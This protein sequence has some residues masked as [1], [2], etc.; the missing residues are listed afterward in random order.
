MTYEVLTQPTHGTLTECAD[1][2]CRYS[3]Q[4]GYTGF[5]SFTF[6]TSDGTSF[7]NT[8]TI[9]IQVH[10]PGTGATWDTSAT[11]APG[12]PVS[13]T[14][15]GY[16]GEQ[17]SLAFSIVDAPAHGSLG[18][19]GP[20]TCDYVDHVRVQ[21]HGRLHGRPRHGGPRGQVHLPGHRP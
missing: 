2:Y 4:A 5:D 10:D 1:T 18:A 9:T 14:L 8:A 17:Q 20:V 13:I 19:L 7:S 12:D 15:E 3:P 6:R 11:A 16:D 21:D